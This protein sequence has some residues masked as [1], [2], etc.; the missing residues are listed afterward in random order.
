[1]KNQFIKIRRFNR[2]VD[3]CLVAS[4]LECEGIECFLPDEMF[5]KSSHNHFIGTSQVRLQVKKEDADKALKILNEKPV[6]F[7]LNEK[8]F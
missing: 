5:A 6:E 8:E 4:R 2:L 3:A 7:F 1:M